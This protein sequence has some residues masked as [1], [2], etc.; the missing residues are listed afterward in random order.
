MIH[1]Q[2]I[3]LFERT[4]PAEVPVKRPHSAFIQISNNADGNC[5]PYALMDNDRLKNV[6][7]AINRTPHHYTPEDVMKYKLPVFERFLSHVSGTT[8]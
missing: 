2:S 8:C 3:R 7:G 5:L 4:F 1:I 6:T